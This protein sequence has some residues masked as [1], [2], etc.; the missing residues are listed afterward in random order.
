[1][2]DFFYLL[3]SCVDLLGCFAGERSYVAVSDLVT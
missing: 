1:M 2:I 3:Y